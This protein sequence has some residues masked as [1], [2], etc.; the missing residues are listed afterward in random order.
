MNASENLLEI[1]NLSVEYNIKQG[2]M[3]EEKK[4]FALNDLSI[5]I[6]KGEILAIAGESGCGKSTLAKAILRLIE[7]KNGEIITREKKCGKKETN[8]LS[9]TNKELKD[10][11]QSAQMIFQNPFS[12]LN[13]KM[14]VYEIIK[15]PLDINKKLSKAEADKIIEKTIEQVGLDKNSLSKYPHEFSGGQRQRIA[16]ARAL[17]LEP[18][19]ILA[20]EPVSALDVSIQAQIINLLKEL[21]ENLNLTFLF[22][23][24]DLSVIRYLADRVGIMYLGELV[25]LGTSEEIFN[26]PKHPYTQALLSAAPGLSK[27]GRIILKGDL[28][29]PSDL[30]TGCKF[31]T[32]CPKAMEI[33]TH[34]HPE[35]TEF[36]KSHNTICHLYNK[37]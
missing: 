2:F 16:I 31:H 25:E 18:E 34:K 33:C 17:I 8:I 3:Q 35:P 32:R 21:K 9:L 37:N 29:S 13:P 6:K 14:K 27:Q 20:D 10:F 12:S 24:H 11:R 23:S 15:E 7:S 22:I 26:S 36:S 30:P 1:K 5:D 19:F 28:P 4:L